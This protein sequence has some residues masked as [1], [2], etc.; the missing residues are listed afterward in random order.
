MMK[1]LNFV[2]TFYRNIYLD[3]PTD[4]SSRWSSDSNHPPQVCMGQ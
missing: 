2:M 4:Q 3:K 1:Y